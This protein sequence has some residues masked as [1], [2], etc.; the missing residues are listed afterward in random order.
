MAAPTPR[1]HPAGSGFDGI[2]IALVVFVCVTL[3]SLTF[4][5]IMLTGRSDLEARETAAREAATRATNDA[6]R[7]RREL[8]ELTQKVLGETLED[9]E[10]I[11][12]RLET[13][14]KTV[15]DDP[16][17]QQANI[18]AGAVMLT[19]LNGLYT[20]YDNNAKLLESAQ[21]ERDELNRSL[22]SL[23]E[24]AAAR[25]Q[26]F[27]A[28]TEQFRQRFQEL[29]QQASANRDA[30]DQ[31]VEDLKQRLE[32]ASGLAAQ[33][34]NA[35]RQA[36]TQLEEQLAQKEQRIQEL[37]TTLASFRPS[38]DPLSMLQVAD[39]SVVRAVPGQNLA[40]ISLGNRDRIKPGMTFSV[41]SRLRGIP[42]DGKGKADLE[43]T[44]TYD[45]TSEARITRTTPG[46]PILEGDLIAN[47]V[48]DRTRQF[49]F[50]VAG[51]FD[52]N[53]DGQIDDPGGQKVAQM[54]ERWG[55]NVMRT[56]DTQTDFVV[57]GAAP[58]PLPEVNAMDDDARR[59]RTAEREA[60]VEAFEAIKAEARALSIPVLTRTQFLHFV[61]YNVPGNVADDK[62][63]L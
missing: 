15:L 2:K 16:R 36:R 34:L 18:P 60:A 14:L 50:T 13:G 47:P 56:V 58:S 7:A 45:T 29:E 54:I 12:A 4:A 28:T 53:F 32:S 1:T 49:N 63:A 17:V 26:E 8:G 22:A 23:N 41:Y 31:Q 27:A 48:Y 42:P 46:D 30:W 57:L 25:E 37:V 51:D 11:K 21:R 19:V 59:Q 61:G 6:Q 3:A 9:P 62:P 39:G 52:L 40:Y 5:V 35:E 44:R 38:T 33:Q 55:G 20:L 10:Q 24:S 43:V